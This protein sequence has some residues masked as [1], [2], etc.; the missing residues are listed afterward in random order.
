MNYPDGRQYTGEFKE[1]EPTGRG[2]M[3]YPDG[4]KVNGEFKAGTFVETE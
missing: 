2:T 4:K 3:I 1:G